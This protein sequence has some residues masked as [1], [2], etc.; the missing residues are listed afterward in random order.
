[1]IKVKLV[2]HQGP[3]TQVEAP[4]ISALVIQGSPAQTLTILAMVRWY[5]CGVTAVAGRCSTEPAAVIGN[6]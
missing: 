1:M 2:R 4:Q 3:S 5:A 6:G